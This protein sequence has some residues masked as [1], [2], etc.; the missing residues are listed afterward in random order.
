REAGLQALAV[1]DVAANV[2]AREVGDVRGDRVLADLDRRPV[3][4]DV[5]DVVL[6]ASVRAAAHLDV[7]PP[8]QLVGDV[9]LVDPLLDRP[10]EAHRAGD[11]ELAAVGPRAADDVCDLAR[12]GLAETDVIERASD[13]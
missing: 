2:V 3:E 5:G 6:A 10:V 4:A 9:H 8:G 11:P 13:V 12:A 1:D 7:D